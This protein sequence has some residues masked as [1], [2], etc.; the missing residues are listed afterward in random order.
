MLFFNHTLEI[1]MIT[2]LSSW[3][4]SKYNKKAFCKIMILR[5]FQNQISNGVDFET[6]NSF[7]FSN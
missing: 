4:K 6:D 7:S 3:Y 5:L 2:I 1:I